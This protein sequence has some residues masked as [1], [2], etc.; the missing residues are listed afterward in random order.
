MD[1]FVFVFLVFLVAFLR[2]GARGGTVVDC[3]QPGVRPQFS[4]LGETEANERS[5]VRGKRVDPDLSF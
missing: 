2:L 3:Y 5:E 4:P 1:W